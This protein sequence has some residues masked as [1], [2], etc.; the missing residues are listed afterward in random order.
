MSDQILSDKFLEVIERRRAAAGYR[1][2]RELLKDEANAYLDPFS[3]LISVHAVLGKGNTFMSN[4]RIDA[5]EDAFV[6]GN[7][8]W[9]GEGT[10]F[11]VINGGQLTIEDDNR[12]GPHAVAFLVNRAE[13]RTV[14]GSGTRLIGRVDVIGSCQL[15]HGTQVIGDV[16]VTNVV[17]GAGGSH[18]EP[19]PDQ[20]GAVLKGH[21]RAHG[22]R[23]DAGQVV[24]GSGDFSVAPVER[25]SS[26]HPKGR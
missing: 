22:L 20:R 8:N 5:A 17:L 13:A 23:I 7:E 3:T 14:V 16:T 9:I 4:V 18:E 24:N 10:R 1:T 25:Q 21:G 19:D 12:I 11:E 2:V 6:L 26:Y 15:G